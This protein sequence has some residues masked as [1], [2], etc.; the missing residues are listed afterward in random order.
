MLK[1]CGINAL[2]KF[3]PKEKDVWLSLKTMTSIL[4]DAGYNVKP[5]KL[6]HGIRPPIVNIGFAK[7]HYYILDDLYGGYPE[8]LFLTA[9]ELRLNGDAVRVISDEEAERIIRQMEEGITKPHPFLH[10]AGNCWQEVWPKFERYGAVVLR[11]L[12][13]V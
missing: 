1:S 5:C 8:V 11:I 9:E 2:E 6:N 10:L 13:T 7:E 12:Q 4:R 3:L